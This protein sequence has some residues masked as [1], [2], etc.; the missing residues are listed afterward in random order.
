MW[1]EKQG[2]QPESVSERQREKEKEIGVGGWV[3]MGDRGLQA[4]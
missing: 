4:A 3:E 1:T 2:L